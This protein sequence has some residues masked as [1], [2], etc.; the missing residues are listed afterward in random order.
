MRQEY[1]F[2]TLEALEAA[3]VE[4]GQSVEDFKAS[5]AD[6]YLTQQ[7]LQR[8]V[9]GR[10]IITTEEMRNYYEAHKAEFDRPEGVRL[11]EIVLLTGDRPAEEIAALRQRAAEALERIR[12]GEDFA[13][14]AAEVS[15][16]ATASVGGDLGFF[17]QGSLG[18][19][20]ARISADL[21]RNQTSEVVELA[22][23]LVILQVQD[24]HTGG[25]LPFELAQQEIQEILWSQRVESY[26]REYLGELRL[27][28]F[29][30]VRGDYVDSG[31]SEATSSLGASSATAAP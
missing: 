4:Q 11:R 8:E 27:Q 29:V 5:I 24:R 26:V 6:R 19:D 20:Y 2:P 10:I 16:A 23:A 15:E 28:G 30:E 14:V 17:E 3:I 21:A 31:A 7:V 9:Y 18:A 12:G 1:D 22:D 13:A 25:I